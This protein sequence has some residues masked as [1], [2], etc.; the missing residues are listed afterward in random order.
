M[1][2]FGRFLA[3]LSAV[4]IAVGLIGGFT[5]LFMDADSNAVRLL[6]LVPLGFVG[7]LTGIVITQLHRPADGN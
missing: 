7:L 6:T 5:A 4:L 3:W 1:H 2:R